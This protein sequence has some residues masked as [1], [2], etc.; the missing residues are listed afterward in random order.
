MWTC[1]WREWEWPKEICCW[2]AWAVSIVLCVTKGREQTQGLNH[3]LDNLPTENQELIL[4]SFEKILRSFSIIMNQI[5][6]LLLHL[7]NVW[8]LKVKKIMSLITWV[9]VQLQYHY[10][11][12]RFAT[13]SK[14][15]LLI[16]WTM[17]ILK[18]SGVQ[19]S[20]LVVSL[21]N[22]PVLGKER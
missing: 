4:R 22:I 7:L 17:I 6:S 2:V 3:S 16:F 13:V 12:Y 19:V 10:S 9:Y 1:L 11:V 18:P 8:S 5:F 20:V 14:C 15:N 21:L